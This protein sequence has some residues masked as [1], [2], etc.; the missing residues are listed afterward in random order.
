MVSNSYYFVI[1]PD[2]LTK[3]LVSI[4]Y[5]VSVHIILLQ[6]K[7]YNINLFVLVHTQQNMHKSISL[8][9]DC[10][11]KQFTLQLSE[12]ITDKGTS[13]WC[14]VRFTTV[15]KTFTVVTKTPY[16]RDKN[17]LHPSQGR[18]TVVKKNFKCTDK[19]SLQ[20]WP[21][22]FTPSQERF[23]DATRT[24]YSRDKNAV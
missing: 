9:E 5:L 3:S 20:S 4:F 13:R 24:L 22:L 2:I 15:I 19:N 23:T 11:W 17:A 7:F 10:S 1:I 12:T 21:K 6:V 14:Q 8:I 16:S 18:F